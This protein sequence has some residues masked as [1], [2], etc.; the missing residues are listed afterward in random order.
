MSF[1]KTML[2]RIP[3]SSVTV[4][5]IFP[6][7]DECN[8]FEYSFFFEKRVSSTCVAANTPKTIGNLYQLSSKPRLL[9]YPKYTARTVTEATTIETTSEK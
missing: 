1:D 8:D 4:H 6:K 7:R 3:I 5:N 9:K 2:E